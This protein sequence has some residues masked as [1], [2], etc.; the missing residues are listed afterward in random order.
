VIEVTISCLNFV[1]F[2]WH[3]PENVDSLL[4]PITHLSPFVMTTS[5]TTEDT[6]SPDD[7]TLTEAAAYKRLYPVEYLRRFVA[8]EVRPDGREKGQWRDVRINVGRFNQPDSRTPADI[9]LQ[10]R[11]QRRT[12]RLWSD[13]ETQQ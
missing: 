4:E 5:A 12:D 11:F 8:E 10:A 6:T 7:R 13:S 9:L 1:E 3:D 2:L